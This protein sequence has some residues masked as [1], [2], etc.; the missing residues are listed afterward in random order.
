MHIST[1][2]P[3]A[4]CKPAR[5]LQLAPSGPRSPCIGSCCGYATDAGAPAVLALAPDAVMLAPAVLASVPL[6]VMLTEQRPLH[7]I[8]NIAPHSRENLGTDVF[9]EN[10]KTQIFI[11]NVWGTEKPCFRK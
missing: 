5:L 9:S 11:E 2:N 3:H 8:E 6:A 10:L 1:V 4:C 7:E